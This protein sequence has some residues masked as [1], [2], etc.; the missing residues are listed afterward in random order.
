MAYR[1]SLHQ[2]HRHTHL[3]RSR[4]RLVRAERLRSKLYIPK[5]WQSRVKSGVEK[6]NLFCEIL[7]RDLLSQFFMSKE[8]NIETIF[9]SQNAPGSGACAVASCFS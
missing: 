3:A 4:S 1:V 9:E 2:P 5:L 7:Y 6:S 8:E